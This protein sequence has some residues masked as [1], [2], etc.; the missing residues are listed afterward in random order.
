MTSDLR[1]LFGLPIDEFTGARNQLAE[2]LKTEGKSDEAKTVRALKRPSIAAWTVNQLARREADA[3]NDLFELQQQ[4]EN[5]SSSAELR[6]RTEERRRA[7]SRLVEAARKILT[8]G[9]HSPAAATM[10]KVTKTLM[11]ASDEDRDRILAGTLERDLSPSTSGSFGP[12]GAFDTTAEIDTAPRPDRKLQKLRTEA[13]EAELEA[14]ALEQVAQAA[15]AAAEDARAKAE[16][17]RRKATKARE[18]LEDQ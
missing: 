14:A 6:T 9:G 13:D 10:D 7:L 18:R 2:R 16:T 15:E 4:I 17:A 11:A 12:F 1:D 3:L 8:E 5:A